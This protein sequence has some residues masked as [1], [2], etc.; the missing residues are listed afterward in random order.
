MQVTEFHHDRW[1]PV[2]LGPVPISESV[3][4]ISNRLINKQ[5][6]VASLN[7]SLCQSV[8]QHMQNGP[9]HVS[10]RRYGCYD[11]L[12]NMDNNIQAS[13]IYFFVCFVH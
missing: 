8:T 3:A 12:R 6:R 13:G 11:E 1:N 7:L 10:S 2:I 4:Q 5:R 9:S